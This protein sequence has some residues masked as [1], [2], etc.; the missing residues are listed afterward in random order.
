MLIAFFIKVKAI[1]EYLGSEDELLQNFLV[2]LEMFLF[3]VAHYFVFSHKPYIDPAAAQVPCIA[4]C[5]RMLDVRDVA[6]DVKEHFVD[7]IPRPKFRHFIRTSAIG[8]S[9]SSNM[10]TDEEKMSV[11]NTENSPLL[12]KSSSPALSKGQGQSNSSKELSSGTKFSDRSYEILSYKEWDGKH[13][14]GSR[15]GTTSPEAEDEQDRNR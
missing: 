10:E 2:V 14:C 1:P 7:P 15:S 12:K 4:A 11:A 6:G 9:S 3:A 8:S 5:L 13:R